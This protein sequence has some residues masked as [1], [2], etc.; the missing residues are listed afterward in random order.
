M[1]GLG[2]SVGRPKPSPV[3]PRWVVEVVGF[4]VGLLVGFGVAQIKKTIGFQ[5]EYDTILNVL[6]FRICSMKFFVGE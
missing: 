5:L 6:V 1:G 2:L 4:R 3:S